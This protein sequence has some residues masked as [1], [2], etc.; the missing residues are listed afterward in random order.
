[1]YGLMEDQ[2]YAE[3]MQKRMISE[4][5]AARPKYVVV[6]NVDT[7]WVIRK[8]SI[9]SVFVWGDR[10]VR[11]LYDQVGVIDIIDT[12][13]TRYLWGDAVAGY[14]PVSQYFVM[15]YKRKSGT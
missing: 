11:D 12:E 6:V 10:F 8:S 4:I 1:M 14:T 9:K 7:S 2:P 5:E 3:Q 13:T 15:V